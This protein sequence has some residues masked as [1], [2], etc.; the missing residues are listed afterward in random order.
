MR[1]FTPLAVLSTT[2]AALV[3]LPRPRLSDIQDLDYYSLYDKRSPNATAARGLGTTA[4]MYIFNDWSSPI[5]YLT[6]STTQMSDSPPGSV[7]LSIFSASSGYAIEARGWVPLQSSFQFSFSN[8]SSSK[9]NVKVD[10]GMTPWKTQYSLVS[11]KEFETG[12]MLA[13]AKILENGRDFDFY[14]F[15]GP[16]VMGPL[17]NSVLEANL[18]AFF[19]GVKKNPQKV[20][21]NG[22]ID[23]TVKEFLN[24]A[25]RCKYSSVTPGAVANLWVANAI[26]DVTSEIKMKARYKKLN[27]DAVLKL[28]NLS[29]LVTAQMDFSKLSS[30]NLAN[31]ANIKL[32]VTRFQ[33]SIDGIDIDGDILVDIVGGLY[34]VFAP[35]L[36]LPY[37]LASIVNTSENKNILGLINAAVNNLGRRQTTTAAKR[38]YSLGSIPTVNFSQLFKRALSSLSPSPKKVNSR[39]VTSRAVKNLSRWMSDPKVQSLPL[40]SLYIPG[41]HDSHAY[42]FDHALS[43]M[44]Y[45]DIAFLWDFDY[46][47]PAPSDG[48]FN[49][50]TMTPIH[51]GPI[52][53]QYTMN[54]VARIAKAQGSN[55]LAQLNGGVRHFD[56]RIYYDPSADTFYSQHG[57]RAKDTLIDLLTQVQK[58]LQANPS[59]A[60][61][62]IL[63]ISHTNFNQ[64]FIL[65]DGVTT[66]PA[67]EVQFKFMGTIRQLEAWAY[68]PINARG[69]RNFNFQTLK[70]TQLSQ[71]TQGSN[72]VLFINP[73]IVLPELSVNTPGWTSVPSSGIMPRG[74][75][76]EL[77]TAAAL[78]PGEI[79]NNV[80]NGLCGR[81]EQD[82]LRVKAVEANG[83]LKQTVRALEVQKG[84]KVQ[85][86]SLDWWDVGSGGATAAEAIVGLNFG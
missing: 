57:L 11:G 19:A 12:V 9:S 51:L 35:V 8:P 38:W 71:I 85:L 54:S 36:R 5:T 65:D 74:G 79:L 3:A 67:V 77:S 29:I 41:T 76:Y 53:G 6:T 70:D 45:S 81:G 22:D 16:G 66:I 23:I 15:S 69:V 62:I 7:P 73:D 55:I 80:L 21:V 48:S 18:G 17:I 42:S 10:I 20:A 33:I 56:L 30:A 64:D 47:R 72:K 84:T 28:R 83:K 58:F 32:S 2:V 60:E 46:Y 59:A 40:S 14:F 86:I 39:A 82:M 61:L 52:L 43:L 63:D 78:K 31:V 49:P 34:P 75:L 1:S 24:P 68:I 25:V 27:Q 4:D 26:L 13:P 50:L 37:K 44:K